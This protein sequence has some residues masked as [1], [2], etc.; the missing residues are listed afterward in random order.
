[1]RAGAASRALRVAVVLVFVAALI[2]TGVASAARAPSHVAVYFLRGEQLASGRRVGGTPLDAMRQLLAGPTRVER[3]EGFRTYVPTRTR[4][5]S[6]KVAQ[7]VATVDL[8]ERFV[9]G[10]DRESLLA[11]LSQVVGTLTGPQGVRAVQLLVNGRVVAARFPGIPLSRPI[12]LRFLQTPN[13]PVPQP[14][15]LRLQPP[16][17]AV[18]AVQQQL[19][20]LGYLLPGDEDGRRPGS[21]PGAPT[22]TSTPFREWLPLGAAVRGRDRVPPTDAHAASARGWRG[23]VHPRRCVVRLSRRVTA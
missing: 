10:R 2:C 18:K 11:R 8:N 1:V 17:P 23:S 15:R 9:S 19:I 7:G 16:D 20:E 14:P 6:V 21:P 12:T 13:V 22:S 5:L 3:E 4:V